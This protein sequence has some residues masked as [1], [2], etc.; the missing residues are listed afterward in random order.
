MRGKD[1]CPLS[2]RVPAGH[3]A[4]QVT[5]RVAGTAGHQAG[6][7]C[8][9]WPVRTL[10]GRSHAEHARCTPRGHVAHTRE[11]PAALARVGQVVTTT[12]GRQGNADRERRA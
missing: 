8:S 2:S 10:A 9:R 11:Q 5:A 7:A 12:E 4:L 6:V 3:K 1:D